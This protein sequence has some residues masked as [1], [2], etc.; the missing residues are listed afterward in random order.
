MIRE[1][2]DCF[3]DQQLAAF[4]RVFER[5]DT[6]NDE[7]LSPDQF[8]EALR[9]LGMVPNQE[10]FHAMLQD[11][12]QGAEPDQDD[13]LSIDLAGFIKVLYYYTRGAD[14]TEDL[15][16]AFAV[17]DPGKTG[18]ITI[19]NAKSILGGL[20]NRLPEDRINELMQRLKKGDSNEIDYAEMIRL[21]RTG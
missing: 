5:C 15:I 18:K 21:L 19:D 17:F 1:P 2:L 13:Q 10:D 7:F 16:S 12:N 9:A 14:T 8:L 6:D 11:L 3:T 20:R 4:K